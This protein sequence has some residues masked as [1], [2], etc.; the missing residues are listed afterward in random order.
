M[1]KVKNVETKDNMILP[2]V[3]LDTLYSS[4]AAIN[5]AVTNVTNGGVA[6][7]IELQRVALSIMVHV[8][9]HK[10]IMILRHFLDKLPESTRKDSMT[11]FFDMFATVSFAADEN[12]KKVVA[13][14]D[15]SKKLDLASASLKP[16]YKAT[17]QKQ[18][19]TPYDLLADIERVLAKATKRVQ[20]KQA[21][22]RVENADVIALADFVKTV[23]ARHPETVV[24]A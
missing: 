13:Q 10:D 15:A 1:T 5:K 11:A 24:A 8:A 16:W 17:K 14:F 9:K 4:V 20:N 2:I 12:T 6:I 23:K 21:D 19:H 22:D 18:V 7:E 3:K